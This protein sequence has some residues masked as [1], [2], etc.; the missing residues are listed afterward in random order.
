M[1]EVA[2]QYFFRMQNYK[3]D[4]FCVICTAKYS[5]LIQNGKGTLRV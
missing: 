1:S 3:Y 5:H 2:I 4:Y